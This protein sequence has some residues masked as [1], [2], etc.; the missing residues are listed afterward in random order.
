MTPDL[1]VAVVGAGP[2][3]LYAAAALVEHSDLYIEVDLFEALPTPWGLVRSGVAPDHPEKKMII[4]RYFDFVLK[5]KQVRFIGN[6]AV[7]HDVTHEELSRHYSAILY[8]VGANGDA[9]L[10]IPGEQLTGSWSAREFVSYYNGHPDFSQLP[11]DLSCRRV[12]IVGNGNVALDAARIL[13]RDPKDLRR[14]EMADHALD[15]LEQSKI[16]EVVILGRRGPREAAYNCPELEEFAHIHEV[17][18]VAH[19]IESRDLDTKR[20]D[21][22]WGERRKIAILRDLLARP[23]TKGNRR[24]VFQFHTAPVS[25]EG[26]VRVEGVTVTGAAVSEGPEGRRQTTLSAGLVLR[27]IGYR[28]TPFPGLPFDAT[29]SVIRNDGGRVIVEEGKPVRGAYVAGWIKR[30]CRGVIG[31]N[32][33]CARETVAALLD[34]F[35]VSRLPAA[36]CRPS[37]EA[38]ADRLPHAVFLAHWAAMDR[39][40]RLAGTADRRP[41]IKFTDRAALLAAGAAAASY[42]GHRA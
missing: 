38:I 23:H 11:F 36:S 40:E 24:L 16:E 27:A 2:A 1:R 9:R 28:G 29:R 3:G 35:A 17:D 21:L 25:L 18:V 15:L 20:P 4:D 22:V 30:G 39:T 37:S 31:T 6:V 12:V 5:H 8:S 33:R 32:K 10:N 13:V 34:D 19:G 41:R 14:T 7:G 42:K 26:T